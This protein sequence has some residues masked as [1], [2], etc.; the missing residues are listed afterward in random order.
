MVAENAIQGQVG[1]FSKYLRV[2]AS[3]SLRGKV[4]L[5]PSAEWGRQ[6]GRSRAEAAQ[7]SGFSAPALT[8][9]PPAPAPNSAMCCPSLLN[10]DESVSY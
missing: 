4:L 9:L 8:V 7:T 1:L 6:A 5:W 3:A 2:S 10:R